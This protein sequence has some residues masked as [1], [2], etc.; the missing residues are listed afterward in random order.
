LA[1]E[2]EG[3]GMTKYYVDV[4]GVYLGG[5]DGVDA[6]VGAI[7][8]GAPPEN[9]NMI[10][11]NGAWIAPISIIADRIN[12]AMYERLAVGIRWSYNA[13]TTKYNIPL[14]SN[15]TDFLLRNLVK[16][17]E[18]R[19]NPHKGFVFN[20]TEKFNI[21]DNGLRELA[22][23]AGEWGDEISRIRLN[24]IESL[25]SMTDQQLINYDASAIDWSINWAVDHQ[26]NGKGW[27]DDLCVQI[28]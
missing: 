20:G 26:N 3:M 9:G 18:L 8:V 24:E 23:F 15:M 21:N 6:P 16:M 12:D 22:I 2:S 28:P 7:E 11:K 14:S 5:F 10:F 19:T 27:F 17:N 13:G 25:S 4:N 1:N